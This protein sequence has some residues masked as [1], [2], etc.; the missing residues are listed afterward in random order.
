MK[1]TE[2]CRRVFNRYDPRCPRCQELMA[3]A[4]P[5]PG[6]AAP[7]RQRREQFLA[8][9]RAHNCKRSGCGP[10]CTAFDW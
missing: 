10:V 9:L 8:E 7:A 4:A 2:E 3:G 6:W 5:R 1:H